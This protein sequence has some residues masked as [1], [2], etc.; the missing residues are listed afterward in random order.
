MDQ[1][2]EFSP[3]LEH[4]LQSVDDIVLL[5]DEDL[6]FRQYWTKY[7]ALLWFPPKEFLHRSIMKVMPEPFREDAEKAIQTALK[8]DK[9]DK[10]I[11]KFPLPRPDA[12]LWYR[13]KICPLKDR[14]QQGKRLVLLVIGDCTEEISTMERNHIFETLI[15][16]NWEAIRFSDM[17]LTIRYVNPA[18]ERLYGYKEGELIG[19]KVTLFTEDEQHTTQEIKDHVMER[20]NWSGELWQV[21]KDKT[22]FEAFVSVQLVYDSNG[23][24]MGF[25]TQS[26]DISERKETSSKLKSIIDERETLLREIHHR[27]KNNLQVI[28]SLLSLQASTLQDKNIRDI[29]QQSQ[30]RINAMAMIHETLYRSDNFSNISYDKYIDTLVQYLILSMKGINHNIRLDVEATDV[31]LS[32]D[33]AVP[34]GLLINEVITNAL[35]YGIPDEAEGYIYIHM[36]SLPRQ[37]Y[38]LLIGDNGRGYSSNITFQNTKS[39]GLKL[40]YSLARQ[41]NGSIE[42]DIGQ[43]GTHYQIEFGE[44]EQPL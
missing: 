41:L 7:E 26:K 21:R 10:L 18:S 43:P 38:R 13:V 32:I 42:R 35:K 31:L 34:L 40:I 39:L 30:Y 22:R 15:A 3:N 19:K 17:D 28:T 12:R 8:E 29:F 24:P 23:Q 9:T 1:A 14:D 4:I 33:T 11:Y 27:V 44:L 5:V 6:K 36:K 37:R 2:S 25:I 16:Q 20:G